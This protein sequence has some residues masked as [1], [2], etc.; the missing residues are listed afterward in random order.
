MKF[1]QISNNK[2]T[3]Q[4]LQRLNYSN[5]I[6]LFRLKE[7]KKHFPNLFSKADLLLLDFLKRNRC[8]RCM[9]KSHVMSFKLNQFLTSKSKSKNK[10]KCKLLF[11]KYFKNVISKRL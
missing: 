11:R 2:K 5:K 3:M 7:F 6:N 8:L 9:D 1:L 10:N 4:R